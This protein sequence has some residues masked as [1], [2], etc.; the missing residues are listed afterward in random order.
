[1]RSTFK[2]AGVVL[3]LVLAGCGSRQEKA[4]ATKAAGPARS[5]ATAAV[6]RVAG[7]ETAVP[8][9]VRARQRAALA[10]RLQASVVELPRREGEP[11]AAGD[12]LVRLDDSALRAG[13][14]AAETAMNAAVADLRRVENLLQKGAA[15]PREREDAESRA[16]A[17]R[18]GYESARE[19]LSY[20]VLRAPFPGRLAARLVDVG[21]VVSPGAPLVEIE[22]GAGLELVA[23]LDASLATA[24]S[25]GSA[26]QVHVDGQPDRL[27]ARVSSLSRAADPATHRFEIRADL[28]AAP[29]LRSGL[30]ARL[31]V[32]TPD[33]E[34]RLQV[35]NAALLRRGGLVGVFVVDGGQARLRWI[36][37]GR[38]FGDAT[39]VRAGVEAGE[40][41]VLEPGDLADGAAVT[42]KR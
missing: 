1:M 42:E 7:G 15:T 14:A 33:A 17:A 6:E 2:V 38:A 22:G 4:A 23:T 28:G 37:A 30:F 9:L 19:G 41:V 24:L 3:G 21:D 8:G 40:K 27:A 32:P 13:I 35:P 25:V 10:S 29:G 18:A 20:A 16:A 11:V 31:L 12:V 34:A 26:L 39:E 5:V 36:A